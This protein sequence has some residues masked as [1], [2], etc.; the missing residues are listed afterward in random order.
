MDQKFCTT[1]VS[2]DPR[3]SLRPRESH[4]G[5]IPDYP[6]LKL[7]IELME[8]ARNDL[9]QLEQR[10]DFFRTLAGLHK[11]VLDDFAAGERQLRMPRRRLDRRARGRVV[12]RTCQPSGCCFRLT[13]ASMTS[14]LFVAL[15]P[16]RPRA[17]RTLACQ[18]DRVAGAPW[19]TSDQVSGLPA[20]DSSN[21]S[22]RKRPCTKD[23]AKL[24]LS[25]TFQIHAHWKRLRLELDTR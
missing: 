25:R 14:P 11:D 24:R 4:P 18:G 17:D 10:L 13:D 23:A 2:A 21:P 7:L 5:V 3:K 22:D 9:L 19:V 1:I 12:S 8:A 20:I 16:E 6:G 15:C